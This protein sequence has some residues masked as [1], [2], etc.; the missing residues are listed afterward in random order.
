M[1]DNLYRVVPLVDQIA[2]HHQQR[3]SSRPL[4]F[5][6]RG[7]SPMRQPRRSEYR[8]QPLRIA[9]RVP[10][11]KNVLGS[12]EFDDD[13][14]PLPIALYRR[15]RLESTATC[16]KSRGNDHDATNCFSV[17]RLGSIRLR[18]TADKYRAKRRN[19]IRNP[20][21]GLPLGRIRFQLAQRPAS[22]A[23]LPISKSAGGVARPSNMM[24]IWFAMPKSSAPRRRSLS[25][26]TMFHSSCE[27]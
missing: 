5:A 9:M 19:H 21:V 3:S 1:F 25:K 20:S 10:D 17:A 14:V 15:R 26:R 22:P 6:A 8:Q 11:G 16:S 12:V 27:P 13:R 2:S 24:A 23:A 18:S 7:Q 4:R